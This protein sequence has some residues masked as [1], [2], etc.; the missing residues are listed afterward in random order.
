[1]GMFVLSSVTE[2]VGEQVSMY[3]SPVGVTCTLQPE[4]VVHVLAKLEILN[5]H[6]IN[7]RN[8]KHPINLKYKK[9]KEPKTIISKK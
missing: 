3:S 8:N 2:A 5:N 1:M 6:E 4:S 7:V 9:N